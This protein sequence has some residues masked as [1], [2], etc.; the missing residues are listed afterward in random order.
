MQ[1]RNQLG[2]QIYRDLITADLE[3]AL[4]NPKAPAY[5]ALML[6]DAFLLCVKM[7]EPP[8]SNEEIL[9]PPSVSGMKATLNIALDYATCDRLMNRISP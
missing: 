1:T 2:S 9:D 7:S 6:A 8:D 5:R 3:G 4:R